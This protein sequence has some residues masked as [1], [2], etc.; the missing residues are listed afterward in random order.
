MAAGQLK[1]LKPPEPTGSVRPVSTAL[2]HGFSIVNCPDRAIFLMIVSF[3]APLRPFYFGKALPDCTDRRPSHRC[4][5]TIRSSATDRG[6][7]NS[8]RGIKHL[9]SA[10]GIYISKVAGL[11]AFGISTYSI[12]TC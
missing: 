11:L 3:T 8:N 1:Y 5:H 7:Y 4:L 9:R 6:D 2:I 10:R 12:I